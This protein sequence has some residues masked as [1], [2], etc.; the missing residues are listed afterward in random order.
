MQF[1]SGLTDTC[2]WKCSL[3]AGRLGTD[4]AENLQY[5]FLQTDESDYLKF[6]ESHPGNT[7]TLFPSEINHK[8]K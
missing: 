1:T 2:S 6:L 3:S 8:R 4:K 5:C 7:R